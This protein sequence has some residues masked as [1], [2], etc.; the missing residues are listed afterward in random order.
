[1]KKKLFL[2]ILSTMVIDDLLFGRQF[3]TLSRCDGR[4]IALFDLSGKPSGIWLLTINFMPFSLLWAAGLE[5]GAV[6]AERK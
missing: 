3:E 2:I 4:N 5:V 1:M 6:L